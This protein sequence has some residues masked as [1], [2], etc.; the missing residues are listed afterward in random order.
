MSGRREGKRGCDEDII[1]CDT[2][3]VDASLSTSMVD[4]SSLKYTVNNMLCISLLGCA[5][6]HK[7][8]YT[9]E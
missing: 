3:K 7:Y 2:L 5:F 4:L 8:M 9:Y 1:H 6:M